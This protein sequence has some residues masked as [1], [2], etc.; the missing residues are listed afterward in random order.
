MGAPLSDLPPA[1]ELPFEQ[2]ESLKSIPGFSHRFLL[3]H[4]AVASDG[5]RDEVIERLRPSHLGHV[6]EMGFAPES[7]VLAEQVH[8]AE[9]AVVD[10]SCEGM[11]LGVD[12]LVSCTTGVVLGIFVA[13]CCAILLMD[14]DSG[15]FG[16]VHSGKKGSEAGIVRRAIREMRAMGANPANV[17]VALSPCIRPPSYEIDFAA[18]IRSDCLEEGVQAAHLEDPG[19]CTSSDLSRYYSYRVEKGRTGRMLALLGRP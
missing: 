5:E 9:V 1:T 2:F 8:G 4:P 16:L 19:T 14:P 18:R 15:S 6:R 7:L 3:R 12:G 10:R 17:H 13:D 11:C